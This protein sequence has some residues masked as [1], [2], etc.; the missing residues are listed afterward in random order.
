M[1]TPLKALALVLLLIMTHQA[2]KIKQG[3]IFL[4][5]VTADVE[6]SFKIDINSNSKT[7]LALTQSSKISIEGK[8]FQIL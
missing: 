7:E 4:K 8:V 3:T 2:V 1:V 5:A 6:E